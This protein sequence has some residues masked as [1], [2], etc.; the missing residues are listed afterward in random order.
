MFSYDKGWSIIT[1]GGLVEVYPAP[2]LVTA[3]LTIW[4]PLI[5][6]VPINSKI[7]VPVEE[8]ATATLTVW[9]PLL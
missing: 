4:P 8:D 3:I 5:A 7:G 1:S 2:G 6:A 9:I